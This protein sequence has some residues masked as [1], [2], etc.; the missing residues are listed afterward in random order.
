MMELTEDSILNGKIKLFQP[1]NGYRAALDP[2][3]L[4]SFIRLTPSQRVLDVG[5]GVGTISMILKRNENTA[6]ITA[7]DMDKEMCQICEQNASTNG[8]AVEVLNTGIENYALSKEGA[9]D[10][11][12]TNPP[13]FEEKSSRIS[14]S[15]KLA[16][17]E[18]ISLVEWISLCLNNL[19]NKGIF[20]IIH[21]VSRLEEILS[22]LKGRAGAVKITPIFPKS[23]REA[24]RIVVQAKKS[25]KSETTI[26]PGIIVHQENGSYSENLRKILSG[27][28]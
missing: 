12:V 21:R 18:T 22:T 1:Q 11:V 13:F 2:I 16:N 27:D 28:I 3:I 5:C 4:A 17:F 9:F 14:D 7:L 25:S 24:N 6:E 15:K 20:S 19:K 10:H 26:L 8:L 23:D